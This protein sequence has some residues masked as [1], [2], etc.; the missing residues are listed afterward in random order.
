MPLMM[1]HA[2]RIKNGKGT[3][4]LEMALMTLNSQVLFDS[5]YNCSHVKH[6]KSEHRRQFDS[7]EQF[8]ETQ[9]LFV[10]VV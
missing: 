6:F 7:C 4:R 9:M 2:I 8:D 10:G 5:V 3:G 1:L